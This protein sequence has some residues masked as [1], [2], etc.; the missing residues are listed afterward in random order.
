MDKTIIEKVKKYADSVRLALP[1]KKII[2][3]GSYARGC[4]T[5]DSDIDVAVIVDTLDN[6]YL[7]TSSKLFQLVRDIDL[8]IEP[9][10]LL[11]SMDNSGFI[12]SITSYGREIH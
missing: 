6:D 11:E 4:E 3:Y 10:L 2:L 12:E 5:S 9:V 1:V 8:R 7:D